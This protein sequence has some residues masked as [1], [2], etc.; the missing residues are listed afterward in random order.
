MVGLD[1]F[2][3]LQFPQ[4][5]F[6]A[7]FS[8]LGS[9]MFFFFYLFAFSFTLLSTETEN[10]QD[11]KFF[12]SYELKCGLVFWL[13]LAHVFVCKS[14]REFKY[15]YHY[16]SKQLLSLLLLINTQSG[17]LIGIG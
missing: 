9:S 12:S 6:K 13:R 2:Y 11:D 16:Y 14:P 17:L 4:S 15:Y 8:S 10:L 1:S 3:D 5:L 7:F